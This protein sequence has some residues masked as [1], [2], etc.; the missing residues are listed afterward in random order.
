MRYVFFILCLATITFFLIIENCKAD[1]TRVWRPGMV[2]Y[3]TVGQEFN[4]VVEEEDSSAYRKQK[5]I[6]ADLK[7][8]PETRE[9]FQKAMDSIPNLVFVGEHSEPED[10]DLD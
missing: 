3:V 9:A 1:L 2:T 6:P 4:F 8:L 7:T 10:K 5:T